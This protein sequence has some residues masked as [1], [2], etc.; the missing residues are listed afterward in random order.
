MAIYLNKNGQQSGPFDDDVVRGQLQ[1]GQVSQVDMGIRQGDAAWRTLGELF[2]DVGQRSVAPWA[3]EN[4]VVTEPKKSGGGC[5]KTSLI[6]VGLCLFFLGI[7]IAIGSR[8]IPSVSC[9]LLEKDHEEI[10]KLQSDL[11]QATKNG[12]S[13]KI[14]LLQ[15]T[16]NQALS[17]ARASQENCDQDKL[18]NNVI[19]G[20]GGGVAFIGLLMTLVGLFVGR[21]K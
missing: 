16:L 17:G 15:F 5:L 19:G 9:D 7:A 18:R 13:D 2:P 21:R 1:S 6:T 10:V 12:D 11:D 8:F 14:R 4:A 20:A 3:A